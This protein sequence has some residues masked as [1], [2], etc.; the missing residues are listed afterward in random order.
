MN[1]LDSHF[2]SLLAHPPAEFNWDDVKS[3]KDRE[4]YLGCDTSSDVWR[5]RAEELMQNSDI[6]PCARRH[7]VKASVGRWQKNKDLLWYTKEKGGP[8]PLPA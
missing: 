3:D 5:Y 2:C 7:S 4:F 1:F 8:P 6:S